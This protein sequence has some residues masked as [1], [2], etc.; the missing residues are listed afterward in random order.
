MLPA[1]IAMGQKKVLSVRER[2][3]SDTTYAQP[4]FLGHIAM[5]AGT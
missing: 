4:A 3:E 2:S 1:R 5:G